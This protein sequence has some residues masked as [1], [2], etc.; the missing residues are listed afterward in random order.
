MSVISIPALPG[1][2]VSGL[3]LAPRAAVGSDEIVS[4]RLTV[5]LILLAFTLTFII[6]RLYTRGARAFGWPSGKVGALHVHH[7]VV[8]IITVLFCALVS[9]GFSPGGYARDAIAVAFGIGAALTLDEFALWLHLKDVYWAPEGRIS[10]DAI[11]LGAL[12]PT[13]L[14]VGTSPLDVGNGVEPDA[15]G[16]AVV[17]VNIWFAVVTLSKGKLAL[18]LLAVFLP[19]VGLVAAVRL[20]KPNSLWAACFYRTEN[21]RLARARVRYRECSPFQRLRRTATDLIGGAPGL[22]AA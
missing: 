16:V 2:V 22:T 5:L 12:L 9:I 13:L 7:L 19:F 6:T 3:F 20:A 10:I 11:L 18:G 21:G 17:A 15:L 4:R 14:L 8:G 1:A